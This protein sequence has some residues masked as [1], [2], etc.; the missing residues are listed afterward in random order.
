M[1]WGKAMKRIGGW[2]FVLVAAGIV[3]LL[4][5]NVIELGDWAQQAVQSGTPK[6]TVFS[7]DT[8]KPVA[9]LPMADGADVIKFDPGLRRI[10]V[11]CSRGAISVFQQDDPDHY[12]KL[13]DVAV[14]RMVHSLAVDPETHNVYAPE[15]D[16]GGKP[17]A[18]MAVYAASTATPKAKSTAPP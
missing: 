15:Q 8:N 18:R 10:Y 4:A 17:V 14:E 9:S 13:P 3:A 6:M 7:F 5:R 1:Q 16:E 11:A 12:R 2:L